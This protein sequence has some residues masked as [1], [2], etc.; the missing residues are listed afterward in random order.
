MAARQEQQQLAEQAHQ[1]WALSHQAKAVA[2]WHRGMHL[3]R[4]QNVSLHAIA[5]RWA[6]RTAAQCWDG[7]RASTERSRDLRERLGAAVGTVSWALC[8]PLYSVEACTS[9]ADMHGQVHGSSMPCGAALSEVR[10][11]FP[12]TWHWVQVLACAMGYRPADHAV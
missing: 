10:V 6:N 3:Q 8:W 2:A 12:L 1:H 11:C 4:S 7:W 9:A 5:S